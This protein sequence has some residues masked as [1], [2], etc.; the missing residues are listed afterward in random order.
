M[1]TKIRTLR[2]IHSLGHLVLFS[3][4]SVLIGERSEGLIGLSFCLSNCYHVFCHL[5]LSNKVGKN[6]SNQCLLKWDVSRII[7][8]SSDIKTLLE[9]VSFP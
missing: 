8:H 4:E 1:V 3:E 6:N 7:A 2:T 5:M 9:K